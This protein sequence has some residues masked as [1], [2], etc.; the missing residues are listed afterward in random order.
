MAYRINEGDA[1]PAFRIKD[2]EGYEITDEDL[3]GS[4]VVIYFYPQDD[5][6]GCTKEACSF[7]DNLAR[8]EALDALVIGISPDSSES[9]DQFQSKYDLNFTLLADQ[10][11]ELCKK[12][13]VVHDGKL[14]R[15]TF[16]VD[17]EG[18]IQWIERPVDVSGHVDRVIQAVQEL[19]ASDTLLP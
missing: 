17:S 3:V 12:F 13:D 1:I 15:I 4:P 14:E 2:S 6:P 5:T 9:H 7:R 10:N 16:V 11:M 19:R 8:L 18:I